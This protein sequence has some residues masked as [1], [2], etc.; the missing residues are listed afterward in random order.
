LTMLKGPSA[1]IS[2]LTLISSSYWRFKVI[3]GDR[4]I[5]LVPV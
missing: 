3:G 5:L 4:S 2:T 1:S